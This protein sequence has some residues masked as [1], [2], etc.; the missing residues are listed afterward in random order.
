MA[1]RGGRVV[2]LDIARRFCEVGRDLGGGVTG[3]VRADA[4]RLPVAEASIDVAVSLCQGAF[5]VPPLGAGHE[6][7]GLPNCLVTCL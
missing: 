1:A 3:W 2:G 6:T 5:G 7:V 4:G